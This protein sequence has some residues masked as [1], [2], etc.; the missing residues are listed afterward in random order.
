MTIS[1]SKQFTT[2]HTWLGTT[3]TTVPTAGL[4]T[5]ARKG[6]VP[7]VFVELQEH[8]ALT[9]DI[10]VATL[11]VPLATECLGADVQDHLLGEPVPDNRGSD[12]KFYPFLATCAEA[13]VVEVAEDVLART[14]SR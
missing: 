1:S 6:Q 12:E 9:G 7:V 4:G 14:G 13:E 11:W 5:P 10:A 3:G 8:P 2:G